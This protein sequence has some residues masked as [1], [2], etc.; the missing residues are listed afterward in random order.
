MFNRCLALILALVLCAPF[1]LL[2]AELPS[3]EL[4]HELH[5]LKTPVAAPD[6]S[7]EERLSRQG[8]HAQLLGDLVPAL[9][10]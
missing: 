6:F 3:P 5:R 9:P 10:A 8:D 1:G 7:L 2:H 4:S